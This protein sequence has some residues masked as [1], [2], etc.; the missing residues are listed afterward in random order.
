MTRPLRAVVTPAEVQAA[1][2]LL[3]D[4]G[5]QRPSLKAALA[6][7]LADAREGALIPGERQD[8]QAHVYVSGHLWRATLDRAA[9]E[10]GARASVRRRWAAELHQQG[11]RPLGWPPITVTF[12]RYAVT[13]EPAV[14]QPWVA[15]EEDEADQV[16]FSVSG[17]AVAE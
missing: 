1:G 2:H 5:I 7:A 11:L 4:Y 15:C 17:P 16:T 10:E 8:V 14:R 13:Y 12:Q 9:V 3:A 6:A